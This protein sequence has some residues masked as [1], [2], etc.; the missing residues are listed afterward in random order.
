[1]KQVI[2]ILALLLILITPGITSANELNNKNHQKQAETAEENRSLTT[3]N[4][5]KTNDQLSVYTESATLKSVL[6]KIAQKSG[7]EVLFDDLADIPVTLDIQSRTLESGLKRI[8]NDSNHLLR[9]SR[10]EQQNLLLI[11]VM[12]LPTGKQEQ[13]GARRLLSVD[14]EALYHGRNQLSLQQ[15]Q[16]VDLVSKR[17][18]ARVGELSPERREALE[19]RVSARLLAES[20]RE[21]QR[22]KRLDK[23][24][25][26][27]AERKQQ[28]IQERKNLLEGYSDDQRATYEQREQE[29]RELMKTILLKGQ[30]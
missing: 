17:W 14:T 4:Y 20:K 28:R 22:A 7:I 24:K 8:L 27:L 12:V 10:D 13:A 23:H 19:K 15:A 21:A 2:S 29:T 9:Y 5:D 11:G 1:M 3:V 25:K 16:Q 6:G 26:K 18:Q 30:N